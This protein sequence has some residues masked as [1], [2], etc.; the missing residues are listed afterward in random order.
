LS[1]RLYHL[2]PS[3]PFTSADTMRSVQIAASTPGIPAVSVPCLVCFDTVG[4]VICLSLDFSH[5]PSCPAF[6]QPGFASRASR[7]FH[8]FGTMRALTPARIRPTGQVSSLISHTR[9]NVPPP[10]TGTTRTSFHSPNQ[11]VR[12]VSGFA[13]S[14]R[15]RRRVLPNRVRLLRTASS[16][17]IALHPV[18][19]RRSYL[20]LQGLGIP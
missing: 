14:Q 15:A 5:P 9:P 10:T 3:T 4:A 2:R 19:Q 17:P 13:F 6:P 1:I 11:R 16:P 7:G 18:S 8:R 20:Q 12:C